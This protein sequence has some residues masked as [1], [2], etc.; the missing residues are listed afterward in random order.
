MKSFLSHFLAE[1]GRWNYPSVQCTLQL[2]NFN[3]MLVLA[4]CVF[5]CLTDVPASLLD[6]CPLL[7]MATRIAC[8]CWT[9]D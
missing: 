6:S 8:S 1:E 5:M 4:T 3:A 9:W 2:R 7:S